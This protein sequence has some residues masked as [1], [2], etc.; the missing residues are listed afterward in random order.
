MSES[1]KSWSNDAVLNELLLAHKFNE[2]VEGVVRQ[3][4]R[5][6]FEKDGEKLEK[7]LLVITLLNG[8]TVYCPT[9][10]F[11]DYQYK[12]YMHFVGQKH[13]FLIDDINL[14]AE[15]VK[16][17]G[18]K[19]K[20]LQAVKFWEKVEHLKNHNLLEHEVMTGTVTSINPNNRVVHLDI[21]S[22]SVFIP[23]DEW[24]WSRRELIDAQVG[25]RVEVVIKS[26]NRENNRVMASRKA[27]MPDPFEYLKT[28]KQNDLVAGKVS[29]VHPI[30]G[31]FITLE[32]GIDVK[33][34]KPSTL[35]EPIVNDIVTCRITRPLTRNERGEVVGRV[36]ILNYPNGK[37]KRN[38]LGS[39]LF[40]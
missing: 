35:E 30:H 31:I 21:M 28:L 36:I 3:L 14:E 16:V 20:A 4:K 15:T 2:L 23:R 24:S 1:Q 39:F 25:E 32:E 22:Q 27:A 33:G 11:A 5:I 13:V 10:E 37:K 12:N 38:D 19:A 17:S 26:A 8:A 18:K 6:P 40:E 7:Q 9:E 34:S 29:E